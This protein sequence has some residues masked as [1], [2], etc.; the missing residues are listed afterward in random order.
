MVKYDKYQ[1]RA[2][3]AAALAVGLGAAMVSGCSSSSSKGST[4]GTCLERVA[5]RTYTPEVKPKGML[6]HVPIGE[7]AL[8]V[9]GFENPDSN[10]AWTFSQPVDTGSLMTSYR[11]AEPIALRVGPGEVTFQAEE[12]I[13]DSAGD[14]PSQ[15]LVQGIQF[16]PNEDIEKAPE[17]L[18]LKPEGLDPNF[19]IITPILQCPEQQIPLPITS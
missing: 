10:G 15:G 17:W 13:P 5:A 2:P 7:S 3:I 18:Q 9:F 6:L 1:W 11:T 4:P 16:P 14:T 8:L 19:D 12:V